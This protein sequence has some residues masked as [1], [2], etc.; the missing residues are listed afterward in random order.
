MGDPSFLRILFD[1]ASHMHVLSS[2]ILALIGGNLDPSAADIT[3]IL[4][5]VEI[6][7]NDEN[8]DEL[9]T[10]LQGSNI[11]DLMLDGK[12]NLQKLSFSDSSPQTPNNVQLPD[13]CVHEDHKP[14]HDSDSDGGVGFSLFD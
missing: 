13:V 10:R 2:Y 14:E 5:A 1:S 11:G 3:K 4:K 12:K 9:L 7:P 8:V 6:I